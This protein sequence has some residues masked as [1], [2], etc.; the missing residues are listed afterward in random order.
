[1][2]AA[3]A[4]AAMIFKAQ[5]EAKRDASLKYVELFA[6]MFT[7]GD[8]YL[9]LVTAGDT[10][11]YEAAIVNYCEHVI[12]LLD[13]GVSTIETI[14]TLTHT[15]ILMSAGDAEQGSNAIANVA[16]RKRLAALV[17]IYQDA[18]KAA[19]LASKEGATS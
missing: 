10:V 2:N 6:K 13:A 16:R 19:A 7:K 17:D 1:M 14:A 5:I 3:Q 18:M 15:A 4:K 9:T 12:E 8:P 11:A